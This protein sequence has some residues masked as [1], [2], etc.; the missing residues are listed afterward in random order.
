MQESK[1]I[2][3]E[4]IYNFI[5]DLVSM[6]PDETTWS[7]DMKK[8]FETITEFL[9]SYINEKPAEKDW[10]K[11]SFD[12]YFTNFKMLLVGRYNWLVEDANRF[13]IKLLKPLFEAKVI[14]WDIHYE[15]FGYDDTYFHRHKDYKKGE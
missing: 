2:T 15:L 4:Q 12:T 1:N 14:E 8:R 5:M 11:D 10:Q 9:N 7:N 13:D 6:V 3:N